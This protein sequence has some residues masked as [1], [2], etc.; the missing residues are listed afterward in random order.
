MSDFQV[1]VLVL[2]AI[3]IFGLLLIGL[4]AY[5][6][7]ERM[8]LLRRLRFGFFIER[9]LVKPHELVEWPLPPE[10]PPTLYGEDVTEEQP[11]GHA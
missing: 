1:A 9:D 2:G 5:V 4:N 6:R 11:P 3:V 10:A 8:P 7:R